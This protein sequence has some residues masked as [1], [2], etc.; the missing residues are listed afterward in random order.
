MANLFFS[1]PS[2][3]SSSV[4]G[5]GSRPEHRISG[6]IREPDFNFG[7]FNQAGVPS[8]EL[9]NTHA[10]IPSAL[11]GPS[12]EHAL[13]NSVSY[14]VNCQRRLMVGVHHLLTHPLVD[15][16]APEIKD[17]YSGERRVVEKT[18]YHIRKNPDRTLLLEAVLKV[19][20]L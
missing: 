20:I 4:S 13:T 14:D 19:S 3:S 12:W 11:F 2:G 8:A 1:D 10:D 17:L 16:L 6:I 15:P 18:M 9:T 5:S 7:Y